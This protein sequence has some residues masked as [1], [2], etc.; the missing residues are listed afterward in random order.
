MQFQNLNLNKPA[1]SVNEMLENLPFGRTK[2]YAVVKNGE[3]KA[4]KLGK[5]TLFL[6]RDVADFL[7]AL[8][9]MQNG[10]RHAAK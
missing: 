7:M 9:P 8:S 6:A 4:T 2:L 1:Y 5:K 3:L 10:G